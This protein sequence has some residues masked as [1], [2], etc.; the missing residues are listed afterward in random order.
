[1]RV[2]NLGNPIPMCLGRVAKGRKQL[3]WFYQ[4]SL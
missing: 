2:E 4:H 3:R 1:M